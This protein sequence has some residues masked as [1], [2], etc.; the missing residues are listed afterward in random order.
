MSIGHTKAVSIRVTNGTTAWYIT[1]IT[2]DGV[3]QTVKWQGSAPTSGNASA[4]DIYSFAITKTAASTYTVLGI[5][6][7]FV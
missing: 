4:S 3:A 2:I 1:A 7:K 6:T 5:Q